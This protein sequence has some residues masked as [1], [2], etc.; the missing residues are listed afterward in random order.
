MISKQEEVITLKEIISECRLELLQ[1]GIGF[2]EDIKLGIMI[3][4]PS[5]AIMADLLASHV[6]F[7]SIG[8]N[9][10]IQYV[11]AVDRMNEE[12]NEIYDP[13]NPAVLRL[14]SHVIK[15]G[16][17]TSTEVSICG[18]MASDEKMTDILL[19]FGLTKFS[20]NPSKILR[21]KKVIRDLSFEKTR[22]ISKKVLKLSSSSEIKNYLNLA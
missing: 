4:V 20:I 7:F 16:E 19:G 2:R 9:D 15:V 22:A 12:I 21:L 1:E 14:I 18:E 5:A 3:E 11:C 10:L 17:E 13:L 6:D 8:T